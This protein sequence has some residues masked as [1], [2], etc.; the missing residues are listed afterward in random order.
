[1]KKVQKALTDI[2][3]D[4]MLS[5]EGT[6]E[7]ETIKALCWMSVNYFFFLVYH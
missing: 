3:Y 1:M 5:K 7:G 2:G 4:V 6:I